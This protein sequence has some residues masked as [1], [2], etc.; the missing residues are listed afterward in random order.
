VP[1]GVGDGPGPH[2]GPRLRGLAGRVEPHAAELAHG[3]QHAIPDAVGG[4]HHGEQGLC[5]ELLDRAEG[6]TAEHLLRGLED[7]AVREGRQAAQRA[8]LPLAEQVPRPVDHGEQG[9]VA[10]VGA[11]VAAAQQGE[12]VVEPAGDL[13]RRHHPHLGGGELD[14]EGQA[15]QAA[16]DG[17][18]VVLVE[19]HPGP[20]RG[21]A[22]AEQR[23]GVGH[24]ELG[25]RVDALGGDR[26]RRAARGEHPQVP[27]GRDQVGDQVRDRLH[28]VLAVVEDEQRRS[29]VELPGDPGAHVG[30][31]P[32][33]EP[34]APGHRV[35]DA[36]RRPDLAE[37]VLGRGHADQLH[38][39]HHR[40]R[41][42]AGD[43]VGEPGLA[44]PARPGDRDD[45][46]RGEQGPHPPQVVVPPEQR[47]GVEPHAGAHRAVERQQ[48]VVD[49][50]QLRSDVGADP[51]AQAGAVAREPVQRG[52]HSAD[53]RL[54]AEQVG[55]EPFV[56]R[57]RPHRLVE[58]GQRGGV[59]S[60]TAPRPGEH[61][62]R[63]RQVV[64][65]APA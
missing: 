10:G 57:T 55:E 26:Q 19:A 48:L 15:V 42:L 54:A 56:V 17:A 12:P 53:R 52:A 30:E 61:H 47:G 63:G 4:L 41:G 29:E 7:E 33:A 36:E 11:P 50:P 49:P 43:G 37:Q 9:L 51:V 14:R 13:R 62:P 38:E 44:D 28:Q 24:A 45:P 2:G 1:V 32:R 59:V 35:A 64:R 23:D 21:R 3:L 39:V 65:G 58:L 27:G 25:Q 6:V 40:L 8:A 22:V 5:H 34:P 46:G 31:L 60:G 20:G 18:H 16:H